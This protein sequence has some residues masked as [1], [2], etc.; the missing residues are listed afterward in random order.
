LEAAESKTPRDEK[1]IEKIK[2]AIEDTT[3]KLKENGC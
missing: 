3:Q 2:L 1:E